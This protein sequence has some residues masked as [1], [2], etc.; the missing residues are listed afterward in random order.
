MDSCHFCS[1]VDG[2]VEAEVVLRNQF[3]SAFLDW[4]PINPGHVLV[5]P[6][7]HEPDFE[8]LS[9]EIIGHLM[10]AVR[11]LSKVLKRIYAP[12][13]I[14]LAVAG[15]DVPHTHM[16]I[17]PMHDYHDLTSKRLLDGSL[18]RADPDELIANALTIQ[19]E[20]GINS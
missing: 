19:R 7:V 5:I 11:S 17:I 20:L 12:R 9:P 3:V 10:Q 8:E 14:G 1:I 16:H 6:H 2:S 13:K 18:K 15:F 4:K